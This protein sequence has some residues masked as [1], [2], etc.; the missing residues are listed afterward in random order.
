LGAS[1]SSGIDGGLSHTYRV[2]FHRLSP[3]NHAIGLV[4]HVDR[5]RRFSEE[6][7]ELLPVEDGCVSVEP[8]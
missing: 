6:S 7:T 1:G 2:T 5:E 3:G 8:T 4:E